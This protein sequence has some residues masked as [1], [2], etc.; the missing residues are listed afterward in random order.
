MPVH[1]VG[2]VTNMPSDPQS[3]DHDRT[4]W[5]TA[6][7][8]EQL[9]G[10]KETTLEAARSH[11]LIRVGRICGGFAIL[12]AGIAMMIL[13]GPGIVVIIAGLSILAIDMPF[14]RRMRD[15]A[16]D[17]ADRA[18]SIIPKKYKLPLAIIATVLGVG[19]SIYLLVR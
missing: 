14:A 17:R 6:L 19:L 7:R 11:L 16:I 3:D 10:E 5:E 13:P 9:T 15:V 4:M 8:A 1:T 2:S 12:I 18:T